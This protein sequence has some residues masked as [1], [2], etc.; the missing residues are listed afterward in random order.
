MPL[1]KLDRKD[2]RLILICAAVTAVSLFVGVKY[3]S[4]AFPEASIDF[5]VTR[6]TSRPLADRFLHL[7][8][9]D[10]AGYRHAAIFGYDEE[11][12]TFL[13][14]E[15]GVA[16]STR[17]LDTTVRLWRWKHRWFR[18]LQKEEM[19]VDVTTRGEVAGFLHQLPEEAPGADLSVDGARRAAEGFL[20]GVMGRPLDGL[21]FVEAAS[22]KRPHRTDHTFTWKL[23]G[24]EVKGSD[25]RLE[26]GVG[27]DKVSGYREYLKVPDT[28]V[29]DYARLR[30]KNEVTGQVDAVLLALTAVAMV[31][32]LVLRIRR[33]DVR[34]KAAAILGGTLFVLL[35]LSQL[36]SIPSALYGYD[37]TSSYEGFLVSTLLHAVLAG[38]GGGAAIFV[39]AAAA[40]PYYRQRFPSRL[41]LTSLLRWRAIRTREFFIGS[42]AGITLTAFFFAYENVFYIVANALGAWAPREVAYS[43]LLSTAFPW[44]Y[45][46]FF[47]FMPAISEEFI[48]RMFSI[49]FFERIFR[50]TVAAVILS[51]FIWGFGHA[52]YP[53]QP[54]WIRGLEVGLAGIV[55][56]AALLRF[57]IVSVVICHFSVDALYTAF[58][59]IRSPNPY[60][61]V[62][63]T[64]S[65][66]IFAILFLIAVVA[67]VRKR[68]F[69]PSQVTNEAEG[70]APPPAPRA[71][72]AAP[73]TVSSY[74]PISG[75]RIAWGLAAAAVLASLRL[76]PVSHFGDWECFR[77]TRSGALD[78]A[79]A[80]L[81]RNGFDVSRYRSAVVALDRTDST[82]AAYLERI[83]GPGVARKF[84]A[85]L[86]PTP[87]WRAR[88]F[89]PGQKEEYSVTLDPATGRD[90]GFARE[91]SESAPGAVIPKE[92]ALALAEK[93]LVAHGVDPRAGEL[94]EQTE[95]DE[96]ARRDH[97][98][99]W[100]FA[101][102]RAGE[103][104]L[105]H[106]VGVQGEV[107][108]SWTR[109]IKIPE[110]WRRTRER[111]TVLTGLLAW[112]KFPYLLLIG[113]FAVFLLVQAIRRGEIPWKRALV[114]GTLAAGATTLRVASILDE[115]WM[116]YDTSVPAGG[117]VVMIGIS[118]F[119]AVMFVFLFG[120]IVGG[121]ALALHPGS[122]AMFTRPGRAP[123]ARDAL[124]AGVVA[125]GFVLGLPALARL[126]ESVLPAA[127]VI[128]GVAFPSGIG[129]TAPFLPPFGGALWAAVFG[130]GLGG[131]VAALLAGPFSSPLARTLLAV[132]LVLSFL[133]AEA[134]GLPEYL[135]G[136]FGVAL[137]A[138][139]A[140]VLAACFL[141]S[142]PLAW[143]WSIYF[144]V[145]TVAALDMLAE[146]ATPYRVSGIV[147]LLLVLAPALWLVRE[148]ARAGK[149][150]SAP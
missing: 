62:S 136:A 18:P 48:S 150:G 72:A 127:A 139:G 98:L 41:S 40:E 86:V 75:R 148:A 37:T 49:P 90:L 100:E 10:D 60:Y 77:V 118:L 39:I 51:A 114:V 1:E 119:L 82:T 74:R 15:V 26:V 24:V 53:N 20:T 129:A 4:R 99:I 31:A 115:Y 104:K 124:I 144:A 140:L 8:G 38:A 11:A 145:G 28:W 42:L 3:F 79:R 23:K 25:Y 101:E 97:T 67:Y 92:Q 84:Y 108:G 93:F 122:A 27:G 102:P 135:L 143:P 50:S 94:K 121:L 78:A 141:R 32:F 81:H 133:P 123:L 111:E 132:F 95:K 5:R 34:W 17:L 146:P 33:G 57:G 117:F 7:M 134:R 128:R 58:V 138:G 61:V 68:G 96:K 65:A 9:L 12:K 46:L 88:F 130:A 54:F 44:V 120:G 110:E 66:G 14:R 47:G 83:A 22:I 109:S 59:L 107:V 19:D 73:P 29:R 64:L 89:V 63:G 106:E 76:V 149:E 35:F 70:S 126:V 2:L 142:N 13:E 80:F 103:A 116:R 147:L 85:D 112:L 131:I 69:L 137:F 30:S 21:A 52:A 43:D 87:L 91:L 56:G 55:F 16:E 105:R 113:A 71:E 6:E 45:V 36:N 125:L